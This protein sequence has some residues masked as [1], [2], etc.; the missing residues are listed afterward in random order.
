MADTLENDA[1]NPCFGCGP[2]NPRGLRLRFA[3]E[4]EAVMAELRAEPGL[5]GWP[6]RL[7]S[8]VLYTA[9]LEAANWCVFAQRGKVGLPT[10]TGA[11][12]LRRW[13]PTGSA[14]RL[15]ARMPADELRVEVEARLGAE[16]VATLE[17]SYVLPTRAE[18]LERMGYDEVPD[19]F[20]G[21]L[22]DA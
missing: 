19:V 16:V 22:R 11:L 15:V 8:G 6:G 5:E 7:H 14:L 18:F 9:M 21:L 13:V 1:R 3:R 17:R 2:A 10:R 20:R 12:A 4:G